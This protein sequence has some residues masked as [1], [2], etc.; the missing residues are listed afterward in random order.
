MT[1]GR[2]ASNIINQKFG[3]VTVLSR[4][5]NT[6]SKHSMWQCR[7]DCGVEFPTRGAALI[8]GNTKSCGCFQREVA[9]DQGWKNETHGHNRRSG[10]SRTYITWCAMLARCE[11][12]D[13]EYYHNCGGRG[14]FVCSRWHSFENFLAD[15]GERPSGLS[16]DRMDGNK[17]YEP[18]NCRWAD[19][20][21]QRHNRREMA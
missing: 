21:T 17:G 10:P 13:H 15:M 20:V 5:P 16:I 18:G 12:P 2:E 6:P 4:L 9:Q 19:R 7:C 11:N 1:K 3:R 8:S 14:V